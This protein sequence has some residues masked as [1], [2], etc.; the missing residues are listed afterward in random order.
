MRADVGND[1]ALGPVRPDP[2]EPLSGALHTVYHS[3]TI[4]TGL[5]PKDGGVC[6]VGT[7]SGESSAICTTAEGAS[8]GLGLMVTS[9]GEYHIMGVL[10]EGAI[11]AK[12]ED[13]SGALVNAPLN[14]E[15]GYA[16]T[17]KVAPA[18]LRVTNSDGSQYEVSI[19]T[20]DHP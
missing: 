18:K 19:G 17:T 2:T 9:A 11:G 1:V 12:V 10:P 7:V 4:T 14:G 3:A 20:G 15:D 13:P 6:F 8:S 5:V 16:I